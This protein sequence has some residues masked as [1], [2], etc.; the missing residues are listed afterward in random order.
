[1]L[2]SALR[3]LVEEKLTTVDEIGELAGVSTSTVYRWIAGQSQPHFDS[4]RLLVR[5]LSNPA[6]QRALLTAFTAGTAWQMR[7]YDGDLDVNQDGR[8]DA[9][10]ALDSAINVV[11]AAGK[12]LSTIRDACQGGLPDRDLSKAAIEVLEEA[13]HQC[14]VTQQ[15]LVNITDRSA[16]RRAMST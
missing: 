7:Y 5:H 14:C 16:R 2:S 13:V 9:N 12:S 8:I 3:R 1:M 4:I 6:A 10:D 11:R 15:V